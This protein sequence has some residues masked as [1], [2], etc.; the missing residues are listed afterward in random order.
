M[1]DRF[2]NAPFGI[3]CL[4]TTEQIQAGSA[5]FPFA[6][7]EVIGREVGIGQRPPLI[8]IWRHQGAFIMGLRD[9]QL[10]DAMRA[11][12][13]LEQEGYPAI[14][15]HSGGA[16]VP[17]DSGVVNVSLILPK[18]IERLDFRHDFEVMVAFLRQCLR[19]Y[20][21]HIQTGEIAGSYC[22]GDYD[23]SIEGRKFCGISQRRQ[24]HAVIIQAFIVVENKGSTRAQLAQD[25][26]RIAGGG[27]SEPHVLQ[28]EPNVMGS[29]SELV[30]L[31]DVTTFVDCVKQ[32]AADWQAETSY[33]DEYERELLPSV[34]EMMTTLRQRYDH[35]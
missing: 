20:S 1:G 6:Y 16:A 35:P 34:D 26:Y 8:H 11:K 25:F 22:P 21:T 18:A 31:H 19:N 30:A 2:I 9:R 17:L 15:R 24:L 10:P 13:W 4:D 14:V 5:L 32:T 27:S 12:A 7:E 29:L 28:V 33:D 3:K 23:L